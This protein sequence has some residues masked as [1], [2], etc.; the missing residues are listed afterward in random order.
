MIVKTKLFSNPVDAANRT[1][2]ALKQAFYF[3]DSKYRVFE[4]S[5]ANSRFESHSRKHIYSVSLEAMSEVQKIAKNFGVSNKYELIALR[6]LAG[7]TG[8]THDLVRDASETNDIRKSGGFLTA[9]ALITLRKNSRK[10]E[11]GF[12]YLSNNE[13]NAVINAIKLHEREHNSLSNRNKLVFSR[14]N[15]KNHLLTKL[16]FY[17]L[18]WGDSI[19][20]G[21]GPI[22][23]K[24]RAQFVSGERHDNPKD[25]GNYSKKL[26][27]K[28]GLTS[29]QTR[30]LVW[31]LE[32][33]K[34]IHDLNAVSSFPKEMR[35]SI[36]PLRKFEEDVY[37][38]L[39]KD[40]GFK[41]EKS[42]LLFGLKTG[43]PGLNAKKIIKDLANYSSEE[44]IKQITSKKASEAAQFVLRFV[45]PNEFSFS[46][47]VFTRYWLK[48]IKQK[49]SKDP[50]LL[51]HNIIKRL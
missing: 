45:V 22:V 32:A 37:F 42:L 41:N 12:H 51:L 20:E 36:L 31:I 1:T 46:K 19:C 26:Q 44:Q 9:K 28:F 6:N 14:G 11:S 38:S 21:M 18:V 34:R 10:N 3:F 2:L 49:E 43:Y 30:K 40:L 23:V 5:K 4:K 13:F 33:L 15:S 35:K 39:M 16:L 17:S 50:I 29:H 47:G 27:L 8:L 7:L 25:L 24:R 48:K